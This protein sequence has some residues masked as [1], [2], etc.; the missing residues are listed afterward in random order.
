MTIIWKTMAIYNGSKP[1]DKQ[2][3]IQKLQFLI[4]NGKVFELT[5]KK[6][7]RTISQNSYLHLIISLFAYETGY[8]AAEVKQEIFKK[9]V[10]PNTFYDGE[11]DKGL[12][13]IQRWR[14][15]ANLNTKEMTLCID[16]FRDYSSKEAGIY[17]PEPHDLSLIDE[18]KIIVENNK[19]YI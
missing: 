4:A 5:E 10:N 7:T 2:R 18:A 15:T 16:R 8:T 3:A 13:C 12:V 6:R 17:L 14:S 1:I 19:Q 11:V 9:I